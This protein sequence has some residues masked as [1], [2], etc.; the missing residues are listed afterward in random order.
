MNDSP[1]GDEWL[2]AGLLLLP[3]QLGGRAV[4]DLHRA[5]SQHR[6]GSFQG[7]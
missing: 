5:A 3:R 4:L 6:P 7:C 2:A 1:G